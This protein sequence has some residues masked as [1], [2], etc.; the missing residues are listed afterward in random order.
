MNGKRAFKNE[1]VLETK[2][3]ALRPRPGGQ[4]FVRVLHRQRTLLTHFSTSRKRSKTT[5][6]VVVA[7]ER[8]V[9]KHLEVSQMRP[10]SDEIDVVGADTTL[11]RSVSVAFG[12]V[13]LS[14]HL[15]HAAANK[16]R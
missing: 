9:P 7:S 5:G 10:V 12:I 6:R 8:E 16:E 4:A 13:K 11:E 15:L 3:N 1:H 14:F 2:N